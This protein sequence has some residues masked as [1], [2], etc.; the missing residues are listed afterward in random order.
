MNNYIV[1]VHL[2]TFLDVFQQAD[3]PEE[4]ERTAERLSIKDLVTIQASGY[5]DTIDIVGHAIVDNAIVIK[6]MKS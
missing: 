1:R 6:E 5:E 2:K 3:T 4:A